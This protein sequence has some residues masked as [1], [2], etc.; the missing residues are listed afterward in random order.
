LGLKVG[1][2]FGGFFVHGMEWAGWG[3]K[4]KS[5]EHNPADRFWETQHH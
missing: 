2:G 4:Q 3:E 1:D 5:S